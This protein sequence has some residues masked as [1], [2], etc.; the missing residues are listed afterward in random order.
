MK[1]YFH[2]YD[3]RELECHRYDDYIQ[4]D[5]CTYPNAVSYPMG[6]W[7]LVMGRVFDYDGEAFCKEGCECYKGLNERS[8]S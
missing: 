3:P 8:V 1:K 4:P 6:C 7:S 2:L 5:W